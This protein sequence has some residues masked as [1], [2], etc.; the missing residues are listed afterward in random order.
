MKNRKVAF[1]I[2]FSIDKRKGPDK[3]KLRVKKKIIQHLLF[4]EK[5]KDMNNI[6]LELSKMFTKSEKEII[7]KIT[8]TLGVAIENGKGG[9]GKTTTGLELA[10]AMP[11]AGL[12]DIAYLTADVNEAALKLF[13][14]K[15][16]ETQ[17]PKNTFFHPISVKSAGQKTKSEINEEMSRKLLA[18]ERLKDWA[19]DNEKVL[20][21]EDYDYCFSVV[22]DGELK[23]ANIAIF[24]LAGGV[25]QVDFD[26]IKDDCIRSFITVEKEHDFSAKDNALKALRNMAERQNGYTAMHIA[27]QIAREKGIELNQVP[28]ERIKSMPKESFNKIKAQ[29]NFTYTYVYTVHKGKLSVKDARK[30]LVEIKKIEQ[31]FGIKVNFLIAPPVA[32][33]ELAVRGLGHLTTQDAARAQGHKIGN[34]ATIDKNQELYDFVRDLVLSVYG[35][36]TAKKYELRVGR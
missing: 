6:K 13:D 1:F 8:G 35:M 17:F 3:I 33:N 20:N 19:K 31:E 22:R 5:E 14:Q 16:C 23:K 9:S 12:T 30:S 28:L 4:Y 36:Y 27:K 11:Y 15:Y 32:F 7:S 34:I 18:E 21:P 24:D 25:N 29:R 10:H 26:Q 2:T